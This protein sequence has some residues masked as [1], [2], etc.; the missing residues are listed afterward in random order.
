VQLDP[1]TIGGLEITRA[2]IDGDYHD[3]TGDI[4]ALDIVGRDLN[5]QASGTLALNDDGHSNLKLHA[6]SPSLVEVGK[7]VNQ[8]ISGIAKVDATVTGN[9]RELQ[10]TG[11]VTGSDFKYGESGALSVSTDY[12]AKMPELNAADASAIATTHATFVTVADRTSTSSTRRPPISSSRLSS[13]RRRSSRS[14]R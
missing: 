11:N 12:T 10:A 5:V 2:N 7:L 8:P 6:D 14:A 3:S 13:T 4:R 9:R 1:S